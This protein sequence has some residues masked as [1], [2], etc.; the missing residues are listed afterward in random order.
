[1]IKYRTSSWSYLV[2]EKLI[3][4]LEILATLIADCPQ[5]LSLILCLTTF[6]N[7]PLSKLAALVSKVTENSSPLIMN[8]TYPKHNWGY[9]RARHPGLLDAYGQ[10]FFSGLTW[11]RTFWCSSVK[12]SILTVFAPAPERWKAARSY[13]ITDQSETRCYLFD[14]RHILAVGGTKC[15]PFY[16]TRKWLKNTKQVQWGSGLS[17]SVIISTVI[18][19]K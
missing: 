1:M 3:S 14:F 19:V 18:L 16:W 17:I 2:S 5:V 13:G 4:S 9:S 15:W 11:T 8:S 7:R 6:A 10:Q 12:W